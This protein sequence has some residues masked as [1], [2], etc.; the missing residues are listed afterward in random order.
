MGPVITDLN[1]STRKNASKRLSLSPYLTVGKQIAISGASTSWAFSGGI[2]CIAISIS[3]VS[4]ILLFGARLIQASRT[5]CRE[6]YFEQDSDA[7]FPNLPTPPFPWG[8]LTVSLLKVRTDRGTA[9]LSL[10]PIQKIDRIWIRMSS[11]I[12]LLGSPLALSNPRDSTSVQESE[13]PWPLPQRQ[14]KASEF[15]TPVMDA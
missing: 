14:G 4:P 11:S 12:L 1:F 7:N 2:A 15:G 10:F 8:T 6:I 5:N 9:S 3:H 13:H